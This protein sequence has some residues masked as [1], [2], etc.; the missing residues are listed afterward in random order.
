MVRGDVEILG[1][2]EGCCWDARQRWGA[3]WW[4]GRHLF[5]LICCRLAPLWQM[6]GGAIWNSTGSQGVGANLR[7]AVMHHIGCQRVGCGCFWSVPA[8]SPQL[9]SMQGPAL[10]SVIL[11]L[12]SLCL[13]VSG[14]NWPLT[15]S[16]QLPSS[17]GCGRLPGA[18]LS[19]LLWCRHHLHDETRDL[20][21]TFCS[22]V[23]F[24][25]FSTTEEFLLYFFVVR[26][27]VKTQSLHFPSRAKSI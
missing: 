5:S 25:E 21:K 4:M 2:D 13:P 22:F 3:F 10:M 15:A 26:K 27:Q 19:A 18:L 11:M 14:P 23:V 24:S 16:W 17:G 8:R 12:P 7:V 6:G 20:L 9:W 1:N